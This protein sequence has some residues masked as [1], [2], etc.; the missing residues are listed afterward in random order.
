MTTKTKTPAQR[1]KEAE[2]RLVALTAEAESKAIEK[3]L[4]LLESPQPVVTPWQEYPQ[5]DEFN[6]WPTGT[7]AFYY[8]SDQ[9]DCTEGRYR[10]IYETA[11]DLSRIRAQARQMGALFPIARGAVESLTNYVIGTGFEFQVQPKLRGSE[12]LAKQCQV[13]I[14]RFLDRNQFV[15]DLDRIIHANSR[16]DGEVF[17]A[18]YPDSR[19]VRVELVPPECVLEPLNSKQLEQMIGTNHKLNHWW[20]GIHT[21]HDQA[22]GRDDVSRPLGYHCVFDRIGDEW[23]YLPAYRVEHIKRNVGRVGRRGVSD[24]YSVL[25][26]LEN[27]AKIRRNTAIGAA[28]LAAIVLIRQHA[29]GVP[30]TSIESMVSGGSTANYQKPISDGGTRT[31]YQ[32]NIRPGTIKDTPYG[33][34]TTAGPLGSLNQPVYI[35]VAQYLLR[36]IG[37]RWNMPE[38]LI[39][40]DASNANMASTFMAGTPFVRSR[41]ADQSLY[42]AAFERLIYKALRMYIALGEFGVANWQ[43]IR[44]AV[45]LKVDYQSPENRDRAEQ[46]AT[47]EVLARNRL[48]SKRTWAADSGLDYDEEQ[49]EIAQQPREPSPMVDPMTGLPL[50]APGI[51][52]NPFAARQAFQ[53][54]TESL[55]VRAVDLL[56]EAKAKYSGMITEVIREPQP[57]RQSEPMQKSVAQPAT[58][59]P[60]LVINMPPYSQPDTVVNV[61]QQEPPSVTVNIPEQKAPTIEVNVPRDDRTVEFEIIRDP[62]TKLASKIRKTIR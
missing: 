36:I 45:M 60:P 42:A 47:N 12:E 19:D 53:A 33:M 59:E 51:G 62:E 40:G 57:V 44:N 5:Y 10:P 56:L 49:K 23:D 46:A 11:Q 32:E 14:D 30:K 20:H 3:T 7:G 15:G 41:E 26:D 24:F 54:R 22:L 28:I 48:L 34:T 2:H 50:Q 27:E 21:V 52:G 38:Y 8:W 13:V 61:P 29:E 31:A 43:T 9:D 55:A 25:Q 37:S 39:S 1:R 58:P 4:T 16:E 18:L 6:R 35:E 17:I